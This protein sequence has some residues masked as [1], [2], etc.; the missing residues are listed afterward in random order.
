MR[1]NLITHPINLLISIIY[2]VGITNAL[3]LI[4]GLDGLAGGV[5][6]IIASSF[7][8]LGIL[9]GSENEFIYLLVILLGALFSFLYYNKHP[10][11]TFLGDTGSLFIGW[12]FAISSITFANK[13]SFSLS[14]L[15]PVMALGLPIF[16][17]LFVMIK[18]FFKRHQYN[19][20]IIKRFK[21]IGKADNI[22][23]HHLIL[24][25]G[26]TRYKTLIIIYFITVITC[27]ITLL[28]WFK[29]DVI[30]FYYSVILIL[31]IIFIV[32]LFAEWKGKINNE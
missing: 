21:R 23:L 13:T 5:S 17:V 26:V 11:K 16:D 20:S 30:N 29:R 27:L 18:R 7:L 14:I 28:S 6:I 4:D 25:A 12:V 8:G 19:D 15:L 31:L 24:S 3:N 10:A 1:S 22:H 9:S 32:R 2:I